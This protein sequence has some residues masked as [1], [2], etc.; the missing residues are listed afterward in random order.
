MRLLRLFGDKTWALLL[1][2]RVF[3]RPMLLL[4][5]LAHILLLRTRL[6]ESSVA[7]DSIEPP[8]EEFVEITALVGD[9]LPTS[10][11][12]AEDLPDE[13][14]E[15]VDDA[16]SESEPEPE[17][18][19]KA[20]PRPTPRADDPPRRTPSNDRPNNPPPRPSETSNNNET[21]KDSGSEDGVEE[22]P[23]E[24]AKQDDDEEPKEDGGAARRSEG[25]GILNVLKDRIYARLTAGGSSVND[26]AAVQAQLDS[27]PQV[28]EVDSP[29]DKSALCPG[30][31]GDELCDPI[32]DGTAFGAL[33]IPQTPSSQAELIV[34]GGGEDTSILEGLKFSGALIGRLG[35]RGSGTIYHVTQNEGDVEFYLG[36]IKVF[37]GGQTLVVLWET[38]PL[39]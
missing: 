26:P 3:W 12:E 33:R 9:G 39:E 31:A 22:N 25:T 13:T 6:P 21:D 24:D 7:A 5:V 23:E 8:E 34:L 36:F 2:L 19:P 18:E 16:S 37:G 10:D 11:T 1:R 14:E 17:P 30:K 27:F 4:A 20:E 38:N 15:S 35:A 32:A 28:N 29:E